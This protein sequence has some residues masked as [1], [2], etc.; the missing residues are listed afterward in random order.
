MCCFSD[1]NNFIRPNLSP[2]YIAREIYVQIFLIIITI[3]IHSLIIISNMLIATF[4][5]PISK[6]YYQYS[7]KTLLY[8]S[9]IGIIVS[10]R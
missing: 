6:G 8:V 10:Q 2:T 4:I 3:I 1:V 7:F 5:I 9:F